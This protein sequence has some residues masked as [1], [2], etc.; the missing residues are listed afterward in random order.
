MEK[1]NP[2][3]MQIVMEVNLAPGRFK[4]F[5]FTLRP[6][7]HKFVLQKI[8]INWQTLHMVPGTSYILQY[9]MIHDTEGPVNTV[10][11]ITWGKGS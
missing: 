7:L 3:P 5:F 11:V 9:C 2:D 8:G 4:F 6:F 10:V 1:K